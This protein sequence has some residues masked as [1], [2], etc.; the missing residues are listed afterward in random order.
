MVN[1]QGEIVGNRIVWD[2]GSTTKKRPSRGRA[3]L[4]SWG[5]AC[6]AGNGLEHRQQWMGTLPLPHQSCCLAFR[7]RLCVEGS[8]HG[9]LLNRT[10]KSCAI[11][12]PKK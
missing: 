10:S 6:C 9:F 8:A 7:S 3:S 2:Q 12:S 11:H 1:K 5:L 4:P